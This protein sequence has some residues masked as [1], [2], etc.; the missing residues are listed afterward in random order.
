VPT[1]HEF[2]SANDFQTEPIH[3]PEAWRPYLWTRGIFSE[4]AAPALEPERYAEA[5]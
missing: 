3:D 2:D 4:H 5:A 1:P